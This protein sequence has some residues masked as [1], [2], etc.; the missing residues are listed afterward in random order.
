MGRVN[1]W[2]G[3]VS[4]T[5]KMVRHVAEHCGKRE[6]SILDVA[7]GNGELPLIIRKQLRRI[8]LRVEVTL[9]D[10]AAGHLNGA[11]NGVVANALSMPF[12]DGEFDIVTSS[13]FLHHLE[14]CE[15][16][17]CINESLRVARIAVIVNDL[18]RS[19]LH[20]LATYASLPLFRS[21]LSRHDAPASVRRAYTTAE[22]KDVLLRTQAARVQT[23]TYYLF[24]LGA[25]AW[26]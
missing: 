25:I 21:R 12:P 1:R 2:F 24:R 11:F 18:R 13:L 4:T 10:K 14:P 3:G 23:G 20:L 8:G 9:L 19:K 5:R 22:L 7:S 16:R 15:I 17:Q 6:L 26:K